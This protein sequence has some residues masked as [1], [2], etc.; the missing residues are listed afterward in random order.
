M[1]TP[2]LKKQAE[3][4][5]Q[6]HRDISGFYNELAK[7]AGLTLASLSVIHIMLKEKDCTQKTIVNWT[8]LPKQTVNA[9]IKNFIDKGIIAQ[10]V[11][12][13]SDKRNKVLAFTEKGRIYALSVLEKAS[14]AEYMAL[15]KLG[16][17][18]RETLIR[19]IKMYK[20]NLKLEDNIN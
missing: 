14:E 7:S 4:L 5:F 9:I 15:D 13:E 20:D 18:N 8:Y 2:E 19:I 6:Y 11:V 10:P 3:T 12:S 16:K 1:Y 17:E